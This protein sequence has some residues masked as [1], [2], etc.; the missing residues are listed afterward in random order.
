MTL[1]QYWDGGTLVYQADS[2]NG[3]GG[4]GTI[5][6]EVVPGVGNELE[7]L[8][9]H[10]FNGDTVARGT[11]INISSGTNFLTSLLDDS[12]GLALGAGTD[13][14]YP[15]SDDGAATGGSTVGGVRFFLAGTMD[16][17]G[18][19]LAVGASDDARFALV[20]RLRGGIPTITEVAQSTPTININ[21]EQVF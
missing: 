20:A 2:T 3:A 9:G 5:S 7:I 8:Y 6:Y 14:S 13:Q 4:G 21:V 1:Q 12:P 11:S 10:I 19:L 18:Q 17:T 16:V 15:H